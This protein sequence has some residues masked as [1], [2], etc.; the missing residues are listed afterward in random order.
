MAL[1]IDESKNGGQF[2]LPVNGTAPAKYGFTSSG[3]KKRIL[4]NAFDMNGVGHIR[5]RDYIVSIW[6][7]LTL[8]VQDS[9]K[10]L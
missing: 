1:S 5:F 7:I 6:G 8:A 9:G 2:G 10:I 3:K 4:L